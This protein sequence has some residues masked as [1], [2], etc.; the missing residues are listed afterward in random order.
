MVVRPSGRPTS[1]SLASDSVR[2][3]D[4]PPFLRR[5]YVPGASH[6]TETP[7]NRLPHRQLTGALAAVA[8]HHASGRLLDV[9]CG[10]KPYADLLAPYVTEHVGLDH[11]DSPHDASRVDVVGT[12][13]DIPLA[14][15]SFDTVL[16]SEVLEHLER[17]AA[18]LSEIRRVLRPGGKLILTT[19][20]VW[21][22][23]EEPR[24]FYRYTRH[25]L[26]YLIRDSRFTEVSV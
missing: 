23:H 5:D 6:P 8:S 21:P 12:A 25:G 7:F 14:D 11:A 18:A 19:P 15:E 1:A 3:R 9:G 4:R 17:P 10:S 16:L 26:A 2:R 24:D 20:F 13:Y 22:L